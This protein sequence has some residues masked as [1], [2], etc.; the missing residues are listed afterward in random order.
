MGSLNEG[1]GIPDRLA[2]EVMRAVLGYMGVGSIIL[3]AIR[4]RTKMV[5]LKA[6]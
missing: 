5:R 3:F 2:N 4:K 1:L 6:A